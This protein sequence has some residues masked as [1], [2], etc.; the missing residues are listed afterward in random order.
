MK[1][2]YCNRGKQL[3]V[4]T[5]VNCQAASAVHIAVYLKQE[6]LASFLSLM[7]MQREAYLG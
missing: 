6:C 1:K 3:P 7:N 2:E 5:S 4:S